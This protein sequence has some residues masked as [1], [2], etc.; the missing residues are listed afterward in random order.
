MKRE[1]FYYVHQDGN[2]I[3]RVNTDAFDWRL[4]EIGFQRCSYAEYLKARK[5]I[6]ERKRQENVKEILEKHND[7]RAA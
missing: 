2:G 1:W 3:M 5:E 6:R 4:A 7:N